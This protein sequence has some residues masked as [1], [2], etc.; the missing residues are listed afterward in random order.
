[1]E[2]D[3]SETVMYV[4]I[5]ITFKGIFGEMIVNRVKALVKVL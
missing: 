2:Y 4:T 5:E 1:M 3:I